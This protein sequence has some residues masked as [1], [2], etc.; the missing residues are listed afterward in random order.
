MADL[1]E[2]HNRILGGKPSVIGRSFAEVWAEAWGKIGPIANSAYAGES[3]FIENYP[4]VINRN[5]YDEQ[6]YFTFCYSP[7]RDD[8]GKVAGMFNTVV[9]TTETVRAKETEEILRRELLHRVKNTMA[10]TNAVVS[11]SIRCLLFRREAEPEYA[12]EGVTFRLSGSLH[13]HSAAE[14]QASV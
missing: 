12:P 9:E 13:A 7:L 1:S 2:G 5:G 3:T 14:Q 6:A 4:L 8:E 10:V 11:A